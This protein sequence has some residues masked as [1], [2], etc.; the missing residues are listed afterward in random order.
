MDRKT[1]EYIAV[2]PNHC[3]A[4]F[5][6][7]A[8]VEQEWKVDAF[9]EMLYCRNEDLDTDLEASHHWICAKCGRGAKELVCIGIPIEW[10]GLSGKLMIPLEVHTEGYVFW[11]DPYSSDVVSCPVVYTTHVPCAKIQ[12][13]TLF[14][15]AGD[16]MD[17][18]RDDV[19]FLAELGTDMILYLR[20]P[21]VECEGQIS[22]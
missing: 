2:C 6:A 15:S 14:L 13:A 20:G 1:K 17:E 5:I 11:N 19:V 4:G 10:N 3:D 22:L 8:T 21:R 9:G 12:G 7:H 18:S 16:L